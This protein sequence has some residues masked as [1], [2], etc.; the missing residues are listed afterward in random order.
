MQP[1]RARGRA[2]HEL[3]LA[4]E[5]EVQ[6]EAI[7]RAIRLDAEI[8]GHLGVLERPLG[9]QEELCR[10]CRIVREPRAEDEDERERRRGDGQLRSAERERAEEPERRE[11]RE[12]EETR[13][14]SPRHV[15]TGGATSSA[16]GVGTRSSTSPTT[17]SADTRCTHSS[18]RSTR[19]CASAGTATAFTSSGTT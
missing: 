13:P 19:R 11:R 15:C 1:D 3:D 18:G 17:S 7:D 5:L 10:D 12:A 6:L 16:R 4:W 14:A 8:G 2:F 9:R